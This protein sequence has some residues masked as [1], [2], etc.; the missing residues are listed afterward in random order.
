VGIFD[1][2]EKPAG[3]PCREKGSRIAQVEKRMQV[4]LKGS[5]VSVF[6]RI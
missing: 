2:E 4:S 1:P 6:R 5:A 3:Q